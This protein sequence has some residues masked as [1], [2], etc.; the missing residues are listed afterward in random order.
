MPPS[1]KK[2]SKKIELD[3]SGV[4]GARLAACPSFSAPMLASPGENPAR[5]SGWICEPKLDGIRGIACIRDGKTTLLSRRGLDIT[6]QYPVLAATLTAMFPLDIMLDGEIIALNDAGQPSFQQLQQ[7]MNLAKEIDVERA[8]KSVPVFYFVFDVLYADKYS[9]TAVTLRER[10]KILEALIEKND[11]VRLLHHFDTDAEL[12]YEACVEQGFEGIVAKRIESHYENGRRSPSWIK[13]KAQQTDEFVVGGYTA[14]QGSRGTSFGAL[15][16][17]QYD[18]NGNFH[19][20]GSVGTGFDDKLLNQTMRLLQP[21]KIAK[22]PFKKRPDEKKQVVWIEPNVVIEAK[23]MD[24]TR[25][26][27]LRAPVF[28]RF[29]DDKAPREVTLQIPVTP[30]PGIRYLSDLPNELIQPSVHF[31]K[32]LRTDDTHSENKEEEIAK[33]CLD[34]YQATTSPSS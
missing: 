24:W 29:R 1:K 27:H 10:K 16:L 9:L 11:Q 5:N 30:Q 6:R 2:A 15:L 28:L 34:S 8:E 17:G 18:Q 19:Y 26:R 23:F 13:I 31:V 33:K 12:A 7:R 20:C 32:E 4:K 21:L 14:G 25:D 22:C 3:F